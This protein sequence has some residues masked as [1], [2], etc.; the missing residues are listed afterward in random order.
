MYLNLYPFN[1]S[2]EKVS[3]ANC[4]FVVVVNS[5]HCGCLICTRILHSPSL[6]ALNDLDK[7]GGCYG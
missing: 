5:L 7:V 3:Y 1:I 2:G 4:N 6:Y